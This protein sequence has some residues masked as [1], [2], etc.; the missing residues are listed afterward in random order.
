MPCQNLLQRRKK[1]LMKSFC[2]MANET[3]TVDAVPVE[4]GYGVFSANEYNTG[5]SE[6]WVQLSPFGKFPN[7]AGLQVVTP[8]DVKNIVNEFNSATNA[9]VRALGLPFYIGHPDHP[10]FKAVYTDHSSKGRI[11]ELQMRHDPDCTV[12]QQFANQKSVEPCAD[13]GL[14]GNVKWNDDGKKIIANEEYHGHS[15]N[16]RLT[17]KGAGWHPVALKSVGFTN[18]P[19]IPVSPITAANENMNL[20]DYINQLLGTNYA[21]EDEMRSGMQNF[22]NEAKQS[23]DDHTKLR[24]SFDALNKK[25]TAMMNQLADMTKCYGANEAVTG[26]VAAVEGT[27]L[28]LPAEGQF[29]T[30]ANEFVSVKG[31]LGT[32]E[33][34]L[35]AANEK[36]TILTTERDTFKTN[37]ANERKQHAEHL[38]GV[39]TVGGFITGDERAKY[40]IELANEA[41]FDTTVT[42]L[43]AL[44]PKLN[45]KSGVDVAGRK[46]AEAHADVDRM[47][48]VQQMVNEKMEKDALTYNAAWDAVKRENPALF[49]AM[50]KPKSSSR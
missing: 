37:F 50:K 5:G 32:M 42:T 21:N 46:N 10:A 11:K 1:F 15:V 34:E 4:I 41:K 20:I 8:D 47:G 40:E 7:M 39:L 43:L 17:R 23:K 44:K 35:Q 18:E 19:G 27:G 14:F 49:E 45:V 9:G 29:I 3:A 16:W 48:Q 31:T 24:G 28:K 25:H 2:L 30:L 38:L 33:G 12:C 26:A 36:V 6:N 22:V 13:H